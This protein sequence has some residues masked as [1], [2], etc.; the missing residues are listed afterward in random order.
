MRSRCSLARPPLLLRLLLTAAWLLIPA[1][2]AL[3]APV[4]VFLDPAQSSVG[5]EALSGDI[6]L[7]IG[8]GPASENRSF[9]V[10]GLSAMGGGLSVGLDGSLANPGLGLLRA[11]GTFLIPALFVVVDGLGDALPLTLIDVAGTFGP[12]AA[13]GASPACLETAFQIDTGSAQGVVDVSIVAAIP[14]PSTGLLVALGL[15]TFGLV[16]REGSAR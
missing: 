9:D 3:A 12:S 4:T 16:R 2:S 7:A 11:D 6:D 5:G 1:G 15:A 13:C 14:E 10:T 8:D